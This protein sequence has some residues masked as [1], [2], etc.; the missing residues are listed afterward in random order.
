M[1]R[2]VLLLAWACM[3]AGCSQALDR[4]R[5]YDKSNYNNLFAI[6]AIWKEQIE[7]IRNNTADYKRLLLNIDRA[8]RIT[9]DQN[10]QCIRAY[11]TQSYFDC[12][13]HLR[14]VNQESAKIEVTTARYLAQK[15]K[16]EKAKQMYRD[17]LQTYFGEAYRPYVRQA[18]N[19]L[20]DLK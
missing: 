9:D 8:A 12:L 4:P 20:E 3:L 7:L 15:G 16:K 6:Q 18:Q 5:E 13:S 19:E 2:F 1:K 17:V 11:Q 14:S 10:E